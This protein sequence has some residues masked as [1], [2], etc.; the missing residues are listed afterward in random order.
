MS[1]SLGQLVGDGV[2]FAGLVT[3]AA[4]PPASSRGSLKNCPME[5][6]ATP[7]EITLLDWVNAKLALVGAG[8]I[9]DLANSFEDGLILGKLVES[10]T[11]QV[12]CPSHHMH[13]RKIIMT[14]VANSIPFVRV[15]MRFCSQVLRLQAPEQLREASWP[16]SGAQ[17]S[18]ASSVKLANIK[19]C[20]HTLD[21]CGVRSMR[22]TVFL[23][24]P[25]QISEHSSDER[26]YLLIAS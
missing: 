20:L 5:L 23:T 15:I 2:Q 19:Q 17:A 8:P 12:G 4:P 11:G 13:L 16:I 1:L 18:R 21:S 26:L 10:L 9:D 22:G 24:D 7:E 14:D 3:P 6:Y 25:L